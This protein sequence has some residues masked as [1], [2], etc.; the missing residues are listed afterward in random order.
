MPKP[1]KFGEP[2]GLQPYTELAV[3]KLGKNSLGLSTKQ[4]GELRAQVFQDMAAQIRNAFEVLG[5]SRI[6][7]TQQVAVFKAL[8]NKVLPDLTANY[9]MVQSEDDDP[10]RLSR[11]QLEKIA[12][13]ALAK[14][15]NTVDVI[16][17][18]KAVDD[19]ADSQ[20]MKL[21]SLPGN[22][23]IKEASVKEIIRYARNSRPAQTIRRRRYHARRVRAA[24][25][26]AHFGDAASSRSA[27]QSGA[28]A[29]CGHGD[30]GEGRV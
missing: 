21:V 30:D 11:D 3:M 9:H 17:G 16:E 28:G 14:I 29:P 23:D 22:V 1:N 10:R 6:W 5:G 19:I 25:A 24:Y 15:P 13:S 27:D 12:A 18:T 2:K 4:I 20:V 26:K 8:L 7:S